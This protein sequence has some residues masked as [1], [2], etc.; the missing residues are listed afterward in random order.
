MSKADTLTVF[1]YFINEG[2][3]KTRKDQFDSAYKLFTK[4][5][6]VNKPEVHRNLI[7]YFKKEFKGRTVIRNDMRPQIKNNHTQTRVAMK[8]LFKK[9]M[10]AQTNHLNTLSP[11]NRNAYMNRFLGLKQVNVKKPNN[12]NIFYLNINNK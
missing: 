8:N 3:G 9:M 11:Y 5:L 4:S 1:Q 7:N 10:N 6:K 12:K 2:N